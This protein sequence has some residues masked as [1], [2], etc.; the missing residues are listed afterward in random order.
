[1]VMLEVRLGLVPGAQRG[2]VTLA[3]ASARE[4]RRSTVS[5]RVRVRVRGQREGEGEG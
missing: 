4:G 3:A 2:M 1:M 5:T